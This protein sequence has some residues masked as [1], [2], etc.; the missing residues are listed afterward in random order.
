MPLISKWGAQGAGGGAPSSPRDERANG[1]V[2]AQPGADGRVAASPR[3]DIFFIRRGAAVRR[4]AV[5]L[6][7]L[8]RDDGREEG[9][10]DRA[11]AREGDRDARRGGIVVERARV[12]MR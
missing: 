2:G 1:G 7:D 8:E 6:E 10:R 9:V 12:G 5:T 4:R 11:R 3:D